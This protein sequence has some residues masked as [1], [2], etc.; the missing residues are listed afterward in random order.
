MNIWDKGKMYP[1][2][3]GVQ[4]YTVTTKITAAVPERAG[5]LTQDIV[6]LFLGIYPK[7]SSSYNKDAYSTMFVAALLVIERN[8][9]QHRCL[10][11]EECVKKKWFIY[12]ENIILPL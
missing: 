8:R 12:T 11:T 9:K 5:N 2:L 6:T 10:S 4:G 7:D 3:V 1:L